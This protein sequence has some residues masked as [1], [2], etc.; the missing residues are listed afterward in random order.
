M[1]DSAWIAF[2]SNALGS[3]IGVIGAV[4]AAWLAIRR[5]ESQMAQATKEAASE[6]RERAFVETADE[7]A[8]ALTK[9]MLSM[10]TAWR[11]FDWYAARDSLD[12]YDAW[13]RGRTPKLRYAQLLPTANWV[14]EHAEI[15]LSQW[16]FVACGLAGCRISIGDPNLDSA[17]LHGAWEAKL[18]HA[19]GLLASHPPPADPFMQAPMNGYDQVA[20]KRSQD[21]LAWF[22]N[23]EPSDG[24]S[25]LVPITP[26]DRPAPPPPDPLNQN[27]AD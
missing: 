11:G 12:I 23:K 22:H 18:Y 16:Q 7:L 25:W 27:H 10:R 1:A 5:Q 9:L 15:H 8:Q 13:L 4:G 19:F 14:R 26:P 21:T 24:R 6:A 3:T 20:R 17:P 2:G